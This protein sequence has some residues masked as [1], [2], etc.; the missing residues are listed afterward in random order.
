MTNLESAAIQVE[1]R[2]ETNDCDAVPESAAPAAELSV[3]PVT[4]EPS[5]AVGDGEK[6]AEKVLTSVPAEVIFHLEPRTTEKK[7]YGNISN[8]S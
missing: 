5:D 7:S 1:V 6:S 2:A 8:L 3:E 4:P